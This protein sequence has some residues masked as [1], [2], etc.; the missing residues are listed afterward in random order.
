MQL[1]DKIIQRLRHVRTLCDDDG[2]R[3]EIRSIPKYE[4]HV[5]LGG[6]IRR[7]T[8]VRLAEKNGVP[9]PA[10]KSDFMKAVCPLEHFPGDALWELFHNTYKWHWSCV[11]SCEDL[12][13]IVR[14]FLEDSHLQGVVHTEFTL[15][16]S[17]LM[18]AFPFDEW[19]DAVARGIKGAKK[20]FPIT[21]AAIL[22]ISRR[23]GIENALNT[24]RQ[25]IQKRPKC[26]CGIGMGG[27]EVK[28]PHH[29]FKEAFELARENNI[30]STVHVSEFA[31]GETTISAIDELR[32]NRLGHALNTIKSDA[33]YERMKDSGIHVE[34]CLLCNY[35]AG[36]GVIDRIAD[37]PI[38]KYY[39][40]G[41]P[42][43]I[44][45]D[46]PRIFGYDLIDNYICL[47]KEADFTPDDFRTIN[48]RAPEFA[49]VKACRE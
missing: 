24:I 46:D 39:N 8:I 27:D 14:E 15:S 25:V 29:L 32:P 43:S 2:L 48:E 16:G 11:K 13:R 34:I 1:R 28:Y 20:D 17:Y 26:I 4:F 22:D 41:V 12:E 40:D 35:V 42:I 10:S 31:P 45:T 33:A 23:F 36:M 37:H 47:M 18:K 6:S 7:E 5:H 44:N 3:N 38:R 19:T 21:A 30:S 9:L 49:F